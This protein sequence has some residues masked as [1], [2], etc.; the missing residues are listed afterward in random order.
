MART[1]LTENRPPFRSRS[2]LNA[3]LLKQLVLSTLFVVGLLFSANVFA[4]AGQ[5]DKNG[6][7]FQKSTGKR[8]CH[9]K[10]VSEKRALDCSQKAPVPGDE[11]VLYGRVVSVTDGD[12][13]KAKIQGVVMNFRMADIDA[14]ETDQPFGSEARSM[15]T[16]ALEGKDVVMLRVDNDPYS[17]LVVQVWIA[18]LHINREVMTRGAAWFDREYAHGSCLY[19]VEN[20]ARDAKRGLWA[21][22]LEKRIEPWIWRQRKRGAATAQPSSGPRAESTRGR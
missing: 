13:F 16:A 3:T 1:E 15:L 4:H 9:G 2:I 18:N 21:L 6:C 5:V 14:P 10:P 8:H 11:D 22:P 20:E 12:T 7:H 17:R 19:L